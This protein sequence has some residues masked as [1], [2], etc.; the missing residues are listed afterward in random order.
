MGEEGNM[1]DPNRIP[2]ILSQL[3]EA[4]KRHPDMRFGQLLVNLLD[5]RPNRLFDVEDDVLGERLSDFLASGAWPTAK[6][7]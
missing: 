4:W 3:E 7:A 1:R 5:D 6:P 2:T